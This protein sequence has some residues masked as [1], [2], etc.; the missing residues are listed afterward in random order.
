MI[1]TTMD[2]SDRPDSSMSLASQ[3]PE[4]EEIIDDDAHDGAL[5]SEKKNGSRVISKSTRE[6]TRGVAKSS[7]MSQGRTRV[8]KAVD[9]NWGN[10]SQPTMAIPLSD[11]LPEKKPNDRS[12]RSVHSVGNSSSLIRNRYSKGAKGRIEAK[13]DAQNDRRA[14]VKNSLSLFLHANTPDDNVEE[15]EEEEEEDD[16]LISDEGEKKESEIKEE[17]EIKA[18]P[19]IKEDLYSDSDIE[20]SDCEMSVKSS[21]SQS[22][23]T[24]KPRSSGGGDDASVGSTASRRRPARRRVKA[25]A[26]DATV[27]STMSRRT[28]TRRDTG[29]DRSVAGSVKPMRVQGDRQKRNKDTAAPRKKTGKTDKEEDAAAPRRTTGKTA[30]EDEDKKPQK[31]RKKHSNTDADDGS[32]S[33]RKSKGGRRKHTESSRKKHHSPVKSKEDGTGTAPSSPECPTGDRKSN[34]AKLE[35]KI[36]SLSDHIEADPGGREKQDTEEASEESSRFSHEYSHTL[37]QFDP[38]NVDHITR[39]SQDGAH[40]TSEIIRHEN[41]TESE[42]QIRELTGLPTFE[43][44]PIYL[45]H[46]AGSGL[47][48]DDDDAASQASQDSH[49]EELRED[50]EQA[51]PSRP[52]SARTIENTAAQSTGEKSESDETIG[53][54]ALAVAAKGMMPKIKKSISS[55]RMRGVAATPSFL[56]RNK[57][58][59]ASSK[60]IEE[61]EEKPH[62]AKGRGFFGNKKK[63]KEKD[64]S[65]SD[66]EETEKKDRFGRKKR[67]PKNLAHQALD[68]DESE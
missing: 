10:A 17:S 11:L 34:A 37:L 15:V 51:K 38:T 61:G 42:L 67:T 7:S 5:K 56:R 27:G 32:V 3:L 66:G 63:K 55:G 13:K 29:G 1:Q 12:T 21:K 30:D 35:V 25:D 62:S 33:S 58:A 6:R 20:I 46:S 60:D 41:G 9:S 19:E 50:Q 26:D 45:D 23:I 28:N 31:S 8:R 22:T 43:T 18:E 4:D 36:S 16:S 64:G 14:A 44:K 47:S 53:D 54:E 49:A 52:S 39:V 48:V 24:R 2:M 59:P 57:K 40:V 65:D 68:D